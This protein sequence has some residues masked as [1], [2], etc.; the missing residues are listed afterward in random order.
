VAGLKGRRQHAKTDQADARHLRE[1]LE[2]GKLP[3]SWIPPVLV[4][5]MRAKVR[6]DRTPS[7]RGGGGRRATRG[8]W[9]LRR[10][11][12]NPKSCSAAL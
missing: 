2:A 12:A 10:G 6:L 7:D 4:R 11:T 1:L 9:D 5:E 3:E 8:R